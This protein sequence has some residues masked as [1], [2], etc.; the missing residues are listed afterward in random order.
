MAKMKRW[1]SQNDCKD[2]EQLVFSYAVGRHLSFSWG[3][4]TDSKILM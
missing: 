3:E 1:K 4:E 2:V